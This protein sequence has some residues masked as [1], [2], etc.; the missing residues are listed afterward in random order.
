MGSSARRSA[1]LASGCGDAVPPQV[2]QRVQLARLRV[3]DTGRTPLNT[4]LCRLEQ[5]GPKERVLVDRTWHEGCVEDREAVC[6]TVL[7]ASASVGRKVARP[8][9][10]VCFSGHFSRLKSR[11]SV[12]DRMK[13]LVCGSLAPQ[14]SDGAYRTPDSE[15]APALH[16][17]VRRPRAG[18]R[19]ARGSDRERMGRA[20]DR[21]VRPRGD[22]GRSELR[23]GTTSRIT[24]R[25][26]T[27]RARPASSYQREWCF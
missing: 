1:S 6:G 27:D 26:S 4:A 11:L 13:R 8:H 3:P 9:G 19:V 23:A 25:A 7:H 24:S 16:Q 22:R 18:A 10:G 20:D 15:H 17:V 12:L 5:D 2:P 21:A 14:F